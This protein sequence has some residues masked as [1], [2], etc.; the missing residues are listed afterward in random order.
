MESRRAI[1]DC[2]Y[3]FWTQSEH[4]NTTQCAVLFNR[5]LGVPMVSSSFTFYRN[6]FL[7]A[8]AVRWDIDVARFNLL[9]E[10]PTT[11][12]GFVNLMQRAACPYAQTGNSGSPERLFTGHSG[13]AEGPCGDG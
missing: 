5:Q 9:I 11:A 1:L 8:L 6:A 7:F 12:F 10:Q 3:T 13:P 2:S 4:L